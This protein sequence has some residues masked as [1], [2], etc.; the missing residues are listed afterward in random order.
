MNKTLIARLRYKLQWRWSDFVSDW[1]VAR[2]ARHVVKHSPASSGAPTLVFF[3][4]S[5]GIL[6]MS[7]NNAFHLLTAL[8]LRLQGVRVVHFACHAGMSR[9]V[10]GTD[11]DNAS[12]RPPCSACIR[13]TRRTYPHQEVHW[14][15]YAE[16]AQLALALQD[17]DLE[18]LG[19][20]AYQDLPLGKLCL[21]SLRWILRR[22]NLPDDEPTRFLLRQYILS[23]NRI[24]Q[25]FSTLLKHVKP[26]AVVLFNGM[27]FPEAVARHVAQ[28][29]EIRVIT[30]EVGFQTYSAFFTDG[31]A[32]AYPI[33]I[34]ADFELSPSQNAR[35]DRYL[36]QRTQG[37]FTMAGIRFW[38]EMKGLDDAFLAHA[39]KYKQIVPVFSN[40]VFDT[41]QV[42]AN[43]IFS[44]MFAWLDLVLEVMRGHP[45][46]YFVLRAHP[47]ENRPGKESR[48]S[49]Q[50]WVSKQEVCT[51]PKVTFVSPDEHLSSYELIQ[52]AKFIMVYNSSIGL[53][54]ALAGVPV[55]CGGKARF[56]AYPTVFFPATAQEY[57]RLAEKFLNEEEIMLPPEFQV[58]ARKF[59][60]YQLYRTSLPFGEYLEPTPFPGFV[61]LQSFQYSRLYPSASP[62]LQVISKGILDGGAFLFPEN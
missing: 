44:D 5:S 28:V 19:Q 51:L 35:L 26:Q 24:A 27:F 48:E 12:V 1:R 9:C 60:Y 20:F 32:T 33:T 45:E 38:P 30:H 39:S 58:N 31:E 2:L 10:L 52:H 57:G 34:P 54:A 62:T 18:A 7:L 6:R 41:S 42:H 29:L 50:T 49:V 4:A 21:P 11:R 43:T 16:D 3:K 15:S 14:F 40:V 25:E 36:D 55:L 37:N 22:H 59:L 23:A 56:T 53:E 8:S 47:D 46:T 17:L 13:H 61:K